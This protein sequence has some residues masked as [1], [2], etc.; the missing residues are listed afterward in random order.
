MEN[1]GVVRT[2]QRATIYI[3]PLDGHGDGTADARWQPE[4]M[5][6]EGLGALRDAF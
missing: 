1:H 3:Y 6:G 2:A 4:Y 5:L